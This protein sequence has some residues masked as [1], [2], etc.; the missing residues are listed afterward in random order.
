MLRDIRVLQA[1]DQPSSDSSIG[2]GAGDFSAMLALTD[3]QAQKLFWVTQN[4]T[5]SLQLRPASRPKD[6]PNSVETT[7]SML[8]DGLQLGGKAQVANGWADQ[9][10]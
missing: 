1:P 4:G 7:E 3:S 10:R 9:N 6:S 8:S 2:S 5:W